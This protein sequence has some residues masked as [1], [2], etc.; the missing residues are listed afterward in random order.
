MPIFGLKYFMDG[1]LGHREEQFE[2]IHFLSAYQIV[3]TMCFG[4]CEINIWLYCVSKEVKDAMDFL[5][6]QLSGRW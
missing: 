6:N 1:P 5:I 4:G 2:A 3:A